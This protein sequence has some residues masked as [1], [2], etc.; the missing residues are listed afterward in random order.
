[1]KDSSKNFFA[2]YLNDYPVYFKNREEDCLRILNSYNKYLEYYKLDTIKASSNLLDVGS[3]DGTFCNVLNSLG[4]NSYGVDGSEGTDFEKDIK[5]DYEDNYFDFII[6]NA[7]IEHLKNPN[8]ILKEI[9]R[10][11]KTSGVLITTTLNFKYA[12][13]HFYDDPTH[14]RPYTNVSLK[15]I[16]E[17]NKFKVN[18]VEP[19]FYDK[20]LLL[21]KLPF[22]YYLAA[23]LPFKNHTFK[24]F[25][26]PKFLR[27][28]T[29]TLICLSRKK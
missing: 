10:L 8:I 13:K 18:M 20:S 26:I 1:M 12:T 7:V 24:K 5:I 11:L 23:N 14:L 19:L 22:K 9:Y 3:G 15:R 4:T 6:F 21:L 29:T 27:G 2:N 16:M 17:L 28:R 25:P